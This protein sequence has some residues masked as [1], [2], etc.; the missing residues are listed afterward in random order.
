MGLRDRAPPTSP[1]CPPVLGGDHQ[2]GQ[3]YFRSFKEGGLRILGG[4]ELQDNFLKASHPHMNR[5]EAGRGKDLAEDVLPMGSRE[6]TRTN[7]I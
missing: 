3:C 1:S 7:A 4:Q 2:A 5:K 6:G